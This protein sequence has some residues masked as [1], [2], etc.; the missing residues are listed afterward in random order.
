MTLVYCIFYNLAKILAKTLF[1][2]RVVHPERMIETGPLILAVNH[3]SYFDPP[4]AGICSRRAVYYLARKSLLKWPF[5]GPLFPD[6]NVIPVERDGNDMSALREVIKKVKEGNGIVLFPEGTRSKDGNLQKAK[7]GIGLVI[8]KTQ[9]PVVPM[10]IFGAYEAFP[11]GTKRMRFTKITVV[12]GEPI[13]FTK[14]ELSDNSRETY[15]RL[16][17]RV[18]EGI[19]KLTIAG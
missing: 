8:A 11:K 7:A 10:R 16:S 2:M 5:F 1:R 13:Y 6:M 12:I 3:S 18:M 4:L 19:S 15:Q 9:A 14:D 17:D